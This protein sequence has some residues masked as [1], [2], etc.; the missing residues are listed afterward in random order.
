MKALI[1]HSGITANEAHGFKMMLQTLKRRR[2]HSIQNGVLLS[3]TLRKAFGTYKVSV[4]PDVFHSYLQN[5]I[6]AAD[7]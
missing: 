5:L 4:N 6:E 1:H 7:H 2:Q 3:A